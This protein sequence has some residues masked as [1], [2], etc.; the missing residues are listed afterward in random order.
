MNEIKEIRRN[1]KQMAKWIAVGNTIT[2]Y[3]LK[4]RLG[5]DADMIRYYLDHK[6]IYKRSDGKYI[7]NK[8]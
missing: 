2:D 6:I 1:V 5:F 4:S 8:G 3:F 7:L